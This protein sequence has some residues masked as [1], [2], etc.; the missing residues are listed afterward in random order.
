MRTKAGVPALLI[1]VLLTGNLWAA[2]EAVY[3]LESVKFTNVF[4]PSARPERLLLVSG[5]LKLTGGLRRG[6]VW[7]TE[8]YIP[9]RAAAP[10]SDRGIF[11]VAGNQI[12]FY[13]FV[14][15]AHYAG[16]VDASGERITIQK[17]NRFG[18]SQTEVWYLVR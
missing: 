2:G 10:R 8:I 13:S 18:Q 7:E 1:L 12:R 5:S 14:T 4:D 16:V 17:I 3:G 11:Q 6:N 15:F 9:Q